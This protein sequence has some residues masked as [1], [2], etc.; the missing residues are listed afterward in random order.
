MWKERT[1]SGMIFAH[2]KSQSCNRLGPF[3][4][5]E[6]SK[7]AGFKSLII[8]PCNVRPVELEHRDSCQEP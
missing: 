7:L 1:K 8:I 6:T 5:H 4:P 3:G 2:P